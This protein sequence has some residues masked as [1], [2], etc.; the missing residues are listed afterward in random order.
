MVSDSYLNPEKPGKDWELP[1]QVPGLV[2]VIIPTYN[3]AHL[4]GETLDSVIAQSYRPLEVLVIDDGSTDHTGQIL[5]NYRSNESDNVFM[6]HI[7]QPR[8]GAQ[9]ARNNGCLI[10]RGEYVQYL[11]SDDL[12]SRDKIQSQVEALKK[13]P[14][15]S[16]AYGPWRCLY[17]S[18]R[19]RSKPGPVFQTSAMNSEDSMLRG[20]LSDQWYCPIHDYLFKRDLVK[21][22]G[23]WDVELSNRQDT[24]YM[25]QVLCSKPAA[26]FVPGSMV[27]YRRH[28]NDHIGSAGNF[29]KNFAATLHILEKWSSRLANQMDIY[30]DDFRK[31]LYNLADTSISMDYREGPGLCYD[32][33]VKIMGFGEKDLIKPGIRR[34]LSILAR[35]YLARPV[36]KIFG[37]KNIIWIDSAVKALLRLQN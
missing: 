21:K 10:S 2:S 3:R 37:E 4:I 27:Y 22:A 9:V 6:N 29:P 36:R 12:L 7:K 15:Y 18:D 19:N 16:L 8:R 34:K 31:S 33:M 26:L 32:M 35:K 25:I 14:E 23:P 11:D 20:Y 13:N 1:G 17:T 5:K 28:Q 30:R 24:D